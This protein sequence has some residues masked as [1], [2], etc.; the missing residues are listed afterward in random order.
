[1]CCVHAMGGQSRGVSCTMATTSGLSA[2][3]ALLEGAVRRVSPPLLYQV[4]VSEHFVHQTTRFG[5]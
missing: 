4:R 2:A 3:W 1:M 5:H